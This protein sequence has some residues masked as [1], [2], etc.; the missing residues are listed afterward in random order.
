MQLDC[1]MLGIKFIRKFFFLLSYHYADRKELWIQLILNT[2]IT[3]RNQNSQLDGYC[4]QVELQ[5]RPKLASSTHKSFKIP[6]KK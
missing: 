6:V 3:I 5:I 1:K 2:L 4:A